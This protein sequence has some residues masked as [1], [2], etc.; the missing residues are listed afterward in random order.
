MGSLIESFKNIIKPWVFPIVHSRRFQAFGVGMAKSG[1]NSI[2][3]I[4]TR[5]YRV[6]HEP[7]GELMIRKIMAHRN[8]HLSQNQIT[9][10]LRKRDRRLW[11]EFDSSVLNFF[12]LSILIEEFPEAKFILTIRDCYSWLDSIINHQLGRELPRFWIP[13]LSFWFRPDKFR[14]SPQERAF[15]EQG[16]YPLDCYLTRW[17]EHNWQV[18]DTVPE[19]RLLIIRTDEIVK[20][21]P[22]IANFLGIPA[23]SLNP[24][25][26]HLYKAPKRFNMLSRINRDFLDRSVNTHCGELMK[27]F[28]PE[29]GCYE[30]VLNKRESGKYQ[31]R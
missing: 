15:A 4:F 26:S 20:Q 28:F 19:S 17:A 16:L 12:V 3:G 8:G 31:E 25:K 18:I 7:E 29:I 27:R 14:H 30:D 13:F 23:E 21:I 9:R 2:A 22:V 1:T 6:D 24:Q 5:Q 10:F 11:L